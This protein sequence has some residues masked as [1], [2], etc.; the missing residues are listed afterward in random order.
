M[1]VAVATVRPLAHVF[2]CQ[3]SDRAYGPKDKQNVP[4]AIAFLQLFKSIGDAACSLGRRD[5]TPT[6]RAAIPDVRLTGQLFDLLLSGYFSQKLSLYCAMEDL[7]TGHQLML[8]AFKKI[9]KRI[10]YL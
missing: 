8:Y 10:S 1:R 5:L 6:L 3:I 7:T 4:L 2:Q 9:P